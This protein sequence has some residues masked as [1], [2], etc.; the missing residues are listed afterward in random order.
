M[1]PDE[2]GAVP[3]LLLRRL[4]ESPLERVRGVSR[5][6]PARSSRSAPR[7]ASAPSS[8]AISAC[9]AARA[10]QAPR[11]GAGARPRCRRRVEER[12]VPEAQLVAR[13]R[14]LADRP[15]QAVA[16]LEDP[17]VGRERVGVDGRAAGRELVD[18]RPPQARRADDEEHLLGCEDDDR[19]RV[20]RLAARR[21][22]P[23]TRI[24]L[25]PPLPVAPEDDAHLDDVATEAA[26]D[27]RHVGGP[28]DQLAVRRGP[29]RAT[30]GDQGDGF[31]EAR[32]A[33]GVRSPDQLRPGPGTR[34]RASDSP[35]SR[36]GAGDR[37]ATPIPLRRGSTGM[38]TWT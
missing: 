10:R 21:P 14:L 12:A 15:Q 6:V 29:V 38:T 30:P 36:R 13:R 1:R 37:A 11:G 19:S 27:P 33:R 2:R 5:G 23:L 26:L 20:A 7:A 8:G 25:R 9:A 4:D 16:L 32:L 24:R 28:A 3:D 18:R 35:G 34:P 17:P 22:T 31:E